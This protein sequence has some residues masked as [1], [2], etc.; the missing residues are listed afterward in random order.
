MDTFIHAKDLLKSVDYSLSFVS[1]LVPITKV[2]EITADQASE[3]FSK[4]EHKKLILNCLEESEGVFNLMNHLEI[5]QLTRQ[6]TN[7]CGNIWRR[8][9]DNARAERNEFLL[10]HQCE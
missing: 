3:M 4:G 1:S 7:I 10:M 8:S 6:L 5:V 9:L 2:P